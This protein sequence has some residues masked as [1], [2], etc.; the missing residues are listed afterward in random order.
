[1]LQPMSAFNNDSMMAEDILTEIQ[2][3]LLECKVCFEKFNRPRNLPC[4][5]VLCLKCICALSHPTQQ[6]LECPFCRKSCSVG[7]T[8]ECRAI[9]DLQELMRRAR[10]CQRLPVD[11]RSLSW[12]DSGL[13]SGTLHLYSAFGGWGKIINPSGI[14]STQQSGEVV[15]VHDGETRVAIFSPQGTY[16]HGFGQR[17]HSSANVCHPLDVAVAASGHVVV[18]DAGDRSV[19][20]FSSTGCPVVTIQNSF[21]LPWGVDVDSR[22]HIL[23]TDA[24]MGT[25]SQ[26][27]MDFGHGLVLINRVVFK[28]LACPRSVASCTVSGNVAVVEHLGKQGD[29]TATCLRIFNSDFV[30]LAQVD[31]FG[32]DLMKSVSLSI[33]SVGFDRNGDVIV[34]DTQRGMVWSLGKPQETPVPTPLVSGLLRP[35]GLT[36][37]RLNVLIVLDSGDHTVKFY[38]RNTEDIYSDK[39]EKRCM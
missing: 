23:V 14:A 20:I 19:K 27:V 39:N 5:H 30:P 17:G 7:S 15:V 11:H 12:V 24:Q 4:G 10:G 28:E 31:S 22:G 13:G 33:S 2:T 36:V 29:F 9:S 25:L 16:L 21:K 35:A 38:I 18:T 6:S 34:G 32:L 8:S 3:N 37:T 1:M 26:V